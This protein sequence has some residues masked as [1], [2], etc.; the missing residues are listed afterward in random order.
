[1]IAKLLLV[2]PTEII[3][4]IFRRYVSKF[5]YIGDFVHLSLLICGILLLTINENKSI[6]KENILHNAESFFNFD[7]FISV[8]SGNVD[9]QIGKSLCSLRY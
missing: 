7:T 9:I 5:K 1:M 4:N 3:Q 6:S 8:I 2:D